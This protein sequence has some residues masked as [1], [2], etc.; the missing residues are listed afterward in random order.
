[1]FACTRAV[2]ERSSPTE[3]TPRHSSQCWKIYSV[4]LLPSHIHGYWYCGCFTSFETITIIWL[5]LFSVSV[6]G[7]D[8]TPLPN[9]G[10]FDIVLNNN[11]ALS[12]CDETESHSCCSLATPFR[13]VPWT[14]IR[15]SKGW[16]EGSPGAEHVKAQNTHLLCRFGGKGI[17]QDSL[18]FLPPRSRECCLL[19]VSMRLLDLRFNRLRLSKTNTYI[20]VYI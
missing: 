13:M 16:H 18:Y 4:S 9:K 1:M 5:F 19:D 14:L 8:P 15:A 3:K 2:L 6:S 12:R 17:V 11:L 20:Y 7:Q 10:F